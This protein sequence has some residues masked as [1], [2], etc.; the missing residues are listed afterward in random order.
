MKKLIIVTFLLCVY[1]LVEAQKIEHQSYTTYYNAEKLEPDSVSWYLTPEMVGCTPS[2]GRQ[3][4]FA[5]DPQIS[6]CPD[7]ASY[8]NS[9]YDRG[10]LFPYAEA[11]CDQLDII[12]C[13]YM[14]N[15]LPQPHSFN[16]GDWK[17]LETQERKWAE[18]ETIRII[19]GGYGSQ[20]TLASGVNIPESCW[21]A[22]YF[23]RKWHGYV[24]PNEDT[25]TGHS[26]DYWE[27][28]DIKR[29]DAITGL[30]L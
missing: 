2:K 5:V 22:I 9:G 1:S 18:S 4:I 25:S 23:N 8:T 6:D 15:M 29:F 13:F 27:V 20:G 11:Q 24:M 21:K 26:Y 19:A 16:D 12:E 7:K 10:H 14:S 28:R 17:A 30:N 3:N